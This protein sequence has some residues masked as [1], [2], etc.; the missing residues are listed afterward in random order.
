M[1]APSARNA[2][3]DRL[4][5]WLIAIAAVLSAAT[6]LLLLLPTTPLRVV[7]PALDLTLD[8]VALIISALIAVLSWVRYRE[9]HE[10][11]ALFQASAFLILAVAN[12]VAVLATLT[13]TTDSTLTLSEPGDDHLYIFTAARLIAGGLLV[14]G[15]IRTLRGRLTPWPRLALAIPLAVFAVV[16]LFVAAGHPMPPLI[17][18]LPGSS[19]AMTPLGSALQL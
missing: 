1:T 6:A 12:L 9:R 18:D 19:P 14:V 13:L 2:S 17:S 10:E 4:D 16:I 5:I 15:G 3:L 8:N 7:A 11:F